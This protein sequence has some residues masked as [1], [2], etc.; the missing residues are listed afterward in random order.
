MPRKVRG[1]LL[2]AAAKYD[3]VHRIKHRTARNRRENGAIGHVGLNVL[4]SL[5]Y[6]FLDCRT[7]RLDPAIATIAGRVGHS[8][9]AVVDALKRL[10]AHGFLDWLRRYV[11][12][13]ERGIRGPQVKQTSNAYAI[14]MPAQLAA[15][16]ASPLPD[17]DTHRRADE[18]AE[19]AAMLDQLTLAER[20]HAVIED[21]GLAAVLARLGA[22]IER[23]ERD[24]NER[25]ESQQS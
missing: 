12:T 1:R 16:L 17:D 14:T 19:H 11:P 20:A 13:G 15:M 24:S 22:G 21:D 5:L 3:Q 10:R 18:A 9:G 6:D 25:N 4:R 7:G 23:K 2:E 8:I